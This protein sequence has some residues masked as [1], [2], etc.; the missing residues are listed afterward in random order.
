MRAL[1]TGA[2]GFVGRHLAEHLL[3]EGDEVI[4]TGRAADLTALAAGFPPDAFPRA[5]VVEADVCDASSLSRAFEVAPVDAVFHLAAST[6]V[7]DVERNR[8]GGFD[9]NVGGTLRVFEAARQLDRPPRILLVS[10][11]HLY[12]PSTEPV[13]ESAPLDLSAFYSLTKRQ[14]EELAEFYGAREVPAIVVRPFN[15]TGPGQN[16]RFV[17]PSFARQIAEAEAGEREPRLTTGNLESIRDFLDVRDVVRAY[18]VLALRGE[19]G[20]VYNVASGVGRSIRSALEG[21]LARARVPVS[22]AVDAARLRGGDAAALVGDASKL[23]RCTGWEPVIPFD[24][25][26]DDL[27][28]DARRAVGRGRDHGT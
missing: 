21:L 25:T 2:A 3:T 13:T 26:L 18:R 8:P 15:H 9:V 6:F 28:D 12:A 10:T 20:E 11:G 22:V 7:P 1:I 27:L 19:R 17:L 4:L 24:R 5:R 23:R 16:P 14:A